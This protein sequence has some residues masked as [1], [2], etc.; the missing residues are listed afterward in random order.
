MAD[1]KLDSFPVGAGKLIPV[2]HSGPASYTTGGETIGTTNNQTGITVLGLGSIDMVLGSGSLSVSGN[3]W[4][5][6]QP[7]GNGARKTY[8]LLWFTATAGVPSL[9]QVA[10]AT[11]LSAE[12]VV[13]GFVGK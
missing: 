4:V 7:T 8:K 11:N 6:V 9:T 13:L 2:N 1:T 12:T 3:H 10:N 5:V